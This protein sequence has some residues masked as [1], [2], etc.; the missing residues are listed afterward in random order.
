M[1]AV[2]AHKRKRKIDVE[3]W[4]SGRPVR[5]IARRL[6]GELFEGAIDGLEL[7]RHVLANLVDGRTR[8]GVGIVDA[9][10]RGG[11]AKQNGQVDQGRHG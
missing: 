11:V 5:N 6:P 7:S 8:R 4:Q 2:F 9:G 3:L 10:I 1:R